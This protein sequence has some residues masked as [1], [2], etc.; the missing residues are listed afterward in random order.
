[1]HLNG[2]VYDP[3]LGRMMSADP[4][5]PDA[6]N[7]QAWNRYSYVGNDPLTFTDPTGHSWLSDF[8]G[9]I[10]AFFRTL[11][12]N[13]IVRAVV[14]IAIAALLPFI[15]PVAAAIASAAVTGLAG[16]KLGD[17]LRAGAIAGATAFAF[18]GVG[19]LTGHTPAFAS[20]DYFANVAG[21]AGVG[22]LS[23]V[24]S[25]GECGPGA[26]SG[27]AGSAATPL[28]SV[29]FRDPVNNPADRFGGVAGSAVIGG[30]ASV[31]GGGK[32]ENGAITAA[33]GYLFNRVELACRG[34]SITA[35]AG[36]H[37][38]LFVYKGEDRKTAEIKQFSL[39]LNQ[40]E[41]NTTEGR[42]RLF[43]QGGMDMVP[44][45]KGSTTGMI[46]LHIDCWED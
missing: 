5:V 14:T 19:E 2:R 33:F 45:Q 46:I 3:M 42:C 1:V 25:G 9:E 28:L 36:T 22:C 31:A 6:L 23:A 26:L 24:A 15:A 12:Q 4:V 32:F 8:F 41:F 11:L 20:P 18:F 29:A 21:H 44:E 37:C 30:F 27:A 13:P 10:G 39:G 35:G 34:I 16:G 43:R 17:M 38:G 40:T 7:P